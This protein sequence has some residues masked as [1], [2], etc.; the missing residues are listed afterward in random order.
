MRSRFFQNLALWAFLFVMISS[1]QKDDIIVSASSEIQVNIQ[2][3]W[4]GQ[5]INKDSLFVLDS[6]YSI[7]LSDVKFY[8]SDI[9]L[10]TKDSQEVTAGF[11]KYSENVFLYQMGRE[12]AFSLDLDPNEF[13][14]IRF[15]LGLDSALN[16]S[17]PNIYAANHPLSRNQDMYWDM[18]NY[19]FLVLEGRANYPDA[20]A[21]NHYMSYHLG[22]DEYLRMVTVPIDIDLKEGQK[23]SLSLTLDVKN[24]FEN[25]DITTFFSFH[26]SEIDKEKGLQMMDNF[27]QSFD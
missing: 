5:E 8:L 3:L 17:N 18:T 4:D 6:A 20:D 27:S 25:I 26:S 19:R 23:K 12:N 21:W 24:F 11:R 10:I 22:G 2:A 13:V 15:H 1:C 7:Q 16:Y 9:T 14:A